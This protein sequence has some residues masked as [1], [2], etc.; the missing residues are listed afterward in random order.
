MFTNDE[1]AQW[2]KT[3]CFQT[4]VDFLSHAF[5]FQINF[6]NIPPFYQCNIQVHYVPKLF[7]CHNL[8]PCKD[9]LNELAHFQLKRQ[10][11]CVKHFQLKRQ[12][13]CVKHFFSEK[14][15]FCLTT[16]FR[17]IVYWNPKQHKLSNLF[18]SSSKQLWLG[19][20]KKIKNKLYTVFS[21]FCW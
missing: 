13:I 16:V 20:K 19:L 15:N 10:Y 7:D 6:K 11:I 5:I 18:K 4:S 17:Q 21:D 8:P 1:G 9:S 3:I 12:Y 2:K 14:F